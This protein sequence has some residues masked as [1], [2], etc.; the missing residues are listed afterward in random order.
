[1]FNII[2]DKFV[3]KFDVKKKTLQKDSIESNSN[4]NTQHT[5]TTISLEEKSTTYDAEDNSN[6]INL[7]NLLSSKDKG[8][9]T[10]MLFAAFRG[11]IK[12]MEKMIELGVKY[13]CL[14]NAG[15]NIIHMAAQSDCPNVIVYRSEEHT[16]ELQSR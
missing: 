14:N 10:P 3:E 13:D 16:S 12:I 11:N 5:K 7:V 9:N 15:L 6:E 8:G 2:I 1:M 4:S